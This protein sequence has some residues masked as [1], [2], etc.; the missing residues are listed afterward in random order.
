MGLEK[1]L[2]NNLQI[3][4]E[5]I[6]DKIYNMKAIKITGLGARSGNWMPKRHHRPATLTVAKPTK[7]PRHR[8]TKRSLRL[9]LESLKIP[10][11]SFF[12]THKI[13]SQSILRRRV[14]VCSCSIQVLNQTRKEGEDFIVVRNWRWRSWR[15]G[16]LEK[17]GRE[18]ER[19]MGKM[20]RENNG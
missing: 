7:P 11:R 2:F 14:S 12:H 6:T 3:N 15:I 13:I 4:K 20:K 18:R 5:W 17:Q 10:L 16:S 1:P 9:H 19:V 8:P